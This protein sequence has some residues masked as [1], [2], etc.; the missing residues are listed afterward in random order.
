MSLDINVK[1]AQLLERLANSILD[2][3]KDNLLRQHFTF[4]A[5]EI[6]IVE[7]WVHELLQDFKKELAE[8]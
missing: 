2:R 7:S 1:S 4:S 5:T 3:D 6:R 8:F